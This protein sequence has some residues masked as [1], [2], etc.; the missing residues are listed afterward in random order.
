MKSNCIFNESTLQLKICS[1]WIDGGMYNHATPPGQN[2]PVWTNLTVQQVAA[3]TILACTA[4]L[5][6]YLA[7]LSMVYYINLVRPVEPSATLI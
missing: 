7:Q 6:V 2:E 1:A 5:M 3:E 4:L